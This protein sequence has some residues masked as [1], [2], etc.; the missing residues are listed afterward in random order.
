MER[1]KRTIAPLAL[2]LFAEYPI[3]TLT[4]PR[5]SGKTTLV[6]DLFPDKPYANFEKPDV[7]AFFESDPNAFIASYPDGAIFDE[8]QRVPL[9]SS[10]L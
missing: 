9:L 7:R 6:R 2:R 5:Q 1:L 4:G 8:I 3:L 10:Y